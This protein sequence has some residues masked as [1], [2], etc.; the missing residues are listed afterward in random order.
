VTYPQVSGA[1]SDA[2][3][4]LT[5]GKDG[6]GHGGEVT[7]PAYTVNQTTGAAGW[8]D[9][10]RVAL[11]KG[12]PVTLTLKPSATGKVVADAVRLVRDNSADTD[13]EARAF[14]YSYDVNGN[15]TGINDTS[16]GARADYQVAYTGLN[17]VA[18]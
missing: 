2:K 17:Q 7:E 11:R 3:F 8:K 1:A 15:L 9:V 4:E 12:D 16:S 18:S 10:G 14:A 6:D 5:H 13:T